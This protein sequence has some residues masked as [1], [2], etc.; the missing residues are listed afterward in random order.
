MQE[1]LPN[2]I[3]PGVQKSGTSSLHNYLAAHPQC[4]MSDPKEPNFFSVNW[5]TRSQDDYQRCFQQ[6]DGKRDVR[7]VGE[8]STTYFSHPDVPERIAGSLGANTRVIV[9]L[10]D[11]IERAMSAYWH[12]AKRFAERRSSE[13]VFLNAPLDLR[14]AVDSEFSSIQEAQRQGWIDTRESERAIGDPYWNFQY[15]RNS[16]YFE[17]LLRFERIFGCERL[18]VVITEELDTHPVSTFSRIAKFLEI[19]PCLSS[20]L[21]QQRFNKTAIPKS[22][23]TARIVHG[24]GRRLPGGRF[25]ALKRLLLS[26]TVRTRPATPSVIRER[27]APM[28]HE[29]NH[30]MKEHLA[31]D[32]SHWTD[33]V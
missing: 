18:L 4:I 16:C 27:L 14:Q 33:R 22:G 23:R 12:M 13:E 8:A 28:F 5:K 6:T 10:R 15:L 31:C 26:S 30:Q 20:D 25:L 9:L 3:I 11:P 21:L 1:R 7:V 29:H 19:D 32:Q 2:L 24:I 17:N